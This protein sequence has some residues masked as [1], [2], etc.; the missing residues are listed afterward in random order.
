MLRPMV[1]RQY[2]FPFV[3]LSLRS[4]HRFR[5]AVAV[6]AK[7][8]ALMPVVTQEAATAENQPEAAGIN[9]LPSGEED[10]LYPPTPSGGESESEDGEDSESDEGDEI[11]EQEDPLEPAYV[12]KRSRVID[13][14]DPSAGESSTLVNS[15]GASE[16]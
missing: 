5:K 16:V 14:D 11:G 7:M 10:V 9:V 12:R 1:S 3:N 13:D 8:E 4:E 6:R 2:A 15:P